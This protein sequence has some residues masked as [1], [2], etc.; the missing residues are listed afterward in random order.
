MGSRLRGNDR[1]SHGRVKPGHDGERFR[2][3]E[4][5]LP[6]PGCGAARSGAPL[7][8]DRRRPKRSTQVGLARLAHIWSPISGKPEIGVCSASFRFASCSAAPGTH[9]SNR[10]ATP[11]R[12]VPSCRFGASRVAG[13]PKWTATFSRPCHCSRAA[14][15]RA[16]RSCRLRRVV[17]PPRCVARSSGLPGPTPQVPVRA[18]QP[19]AYSYVPLPSLLPTRPSSR[20]NAHGEKIVRCAALHR[21]KPAGR[22]AQEPLRNR[23][24]TTSGRIVGWR[25]MLFSSWPNMPARANV[26]FAGKQ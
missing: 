5:P 23:H 26:S 17:R 7:I 22:N 19:R 6:C 14:L 9:S 12:R 2:A 10:G 24:I 13:A 15:S 11:A 1:E 8:R 4:E 16:P 21:C 20:D 18:L 3:T 25:R